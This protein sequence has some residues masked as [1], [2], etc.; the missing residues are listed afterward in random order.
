M[1]VTQKLVR[2]ANAQGL[3]SD[4]LN[5]K[6]RQWVQRSLFEKSLQVVSDAHA[7]FRSTALGINKPVQ[8][9]KECHGLRLPLEMTY[10][11]THSQVL[12]SVAG[13]T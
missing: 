12:P 7:G 5:Q 10:L 13:A 2:N 9:R 6:L 1:S 8:Y 3:T 11:L 4:L